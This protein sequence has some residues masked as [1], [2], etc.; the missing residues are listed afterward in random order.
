MVT[1]VD[2]AMDTPIDF[3]KRLVNVWQTLKQDL[4]TPADWVKT[5]AWQYKASLLEAKEEADE[6]D[7]LTMDQFKEKTEELREDLGQGTTNQSPNEFF[8]K[9]VDSVGGE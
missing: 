5:A 2:P 7:S 1:L 4:E 9:A 6:D 8:Q 3:Q